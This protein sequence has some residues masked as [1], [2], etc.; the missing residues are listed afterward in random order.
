MKYVSAPCLRK[1][2]I[3]I[4]LYTLIF[5]TLSRAAERLLYKNFCPSF[6]KKRVV[7]KV[8][9]YDLTPYAICPGMVFKTSGVC[10]IMK[11]A[12]RRAARGIVSQFFQARAMVRSGFSFMGRTS[13]PSS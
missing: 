6:L 11:E 7:C 9:P 8:K 3:R 12:K 10:F 13:I 2:Q 4:F 1:K 5:L